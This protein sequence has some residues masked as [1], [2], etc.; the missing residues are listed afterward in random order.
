MKLKN[1]LFIIITLVI[2]VIGMTLFGVFGFNQTVDYNKSFEVRVSVEQNVASAKETMLTETNAYFASKGIKAKDYAFQTLGEGETLIYK[3]ANAIPADVSGLEAHLES[4]IADNDI[5]VNMDEVVGNNKFDIGWLLLAIGLA[6]VASFVYAII[7]EKLA[8]SVAVAFSSIASF[9]VFVA[10]MGLT[11][12]PAYPFV[13][14]AAAL[15]AAFGGLL[16]IA[17][18]ARLREEFKNAERPNA[19]E[20]AEKVMK[21]EGKKYLFTIIAV[22]VAAVA[23][24]AFI[25]PYM[26]IVAGQ[27]ALAA[28]SAVGVSY[29]GTPLIW[30]AIKSKKSK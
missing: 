19:K 9:I 14:A 17:T 25:S 11:R 2:T 10:L 4:K 23:L 15:A 22:L 26:M 6:I 8:A 27:I 29:F 20:I 21:E 16:S 13:G 24:A 5:T 7:M 1:K 18:A 30:S 12:L 28:L 3:F